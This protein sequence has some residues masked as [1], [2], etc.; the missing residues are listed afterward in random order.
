MDYEGKY[1][2]RWA[3][4][5]DSYNLP[6]LAGEWADHEISGS[7]TLLDAAISELG[8]RRRLQRSRLMDSMH[9][10]PGD[11]SLEP[12]C[13]QVFILPDAYALSRYG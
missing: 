9:I 12:P 2:N 11:Y 4:P 10:R 6:I 1:K 5:S 7:L 8:T 3:F 13:K